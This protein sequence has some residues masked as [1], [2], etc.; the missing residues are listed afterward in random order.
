MRTPPRILPPP[1]DLDAA[2]QGLRLLRGGAMLLAEAA[3]V[4]SVLERIASEAATLACAAEIVIH[5][6]RSEHHASAER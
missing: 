4:D 3:G 6:R 2:A 1:P 5:D